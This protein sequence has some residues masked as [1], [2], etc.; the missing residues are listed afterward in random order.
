MSVEDRGTQ[1]VH[2][3]DRPSHYPKPR[4]CRLVVRPP[5]VGALPREPFWTPGAG[6]AA[7]AADFGQPPS[8]AGPPSLRA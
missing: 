8:R 2:S 3:E 1:A 5:S 4:S 7:E 6:H